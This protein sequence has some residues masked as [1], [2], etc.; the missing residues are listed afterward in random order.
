MQFYQIILL[1][2]IYKNSHSSTYLSPYYIVRFL[3]FCHSEVC[4][5]YVITFLIYMCLIKISIWVFLWSTLSICMY[6][7]TFL[8]SYLF[9]SY[10]F[11]CVIYVC[12]TS[13]IYVSQISSATSG[14]FSHSS[15]FS[16]QKFYSHFLPNNEYE[17]L[18]IDFKPFILL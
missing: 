16:E 15:Y 14:L 3:N 6:S 12:W 17:E 11:I 9:L 10:W 7:I 1:P 4:V 5:W 13:P 2:T 8:L 18:L